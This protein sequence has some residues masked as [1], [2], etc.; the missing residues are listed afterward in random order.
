MKI[1]YGDCGVIIQSGG[2]EPGCLAS[3]PPPTGAGYF[4][5]LSID[6]CPF[7][8]GAHPDLLAAA[9]TLKCHYCS[10]MEGLAAAGTASVI[11]PLTRMHPVVTQG[12]RFP[13]AER[14]SA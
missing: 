3:D 10:L 9:R 14:S 2:S 8:N 1:V 6:S 12:M 4:M 11:W 7:G 5:L 13:A